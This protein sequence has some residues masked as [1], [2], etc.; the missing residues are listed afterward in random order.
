MA[1]GTGGFVEELKDLLYRH[2]GLFPPELPHVWTL[3]PIDGD[4]LKTI[5]DLESVCL[6]LGPNRNLT[7]LTGSILALHP[8][9]QVLSHGGN[10]VLP[11]E[12]INF[13]KEYS[14][15]KFQ[16]FCQFA[17]VMSQNGDKGSFGGSVVMTHA[18]RNHER[19][20]RVFRKRYGR[21]LIKEEVRSLVWKE[22]H[23]VDDFV[24][25]N[26]IDLAELL[27][28][29]EKLRFMM[30]VRNPI[31]VAYSF[32]VQH[33]IREKYF[34]HLD[35]QDHRLILD[36]V[37]ERMAKVLRLREEETERVF[38]F[39]E[40]EIGVDLF[41]RMARFL[42]I[43][44]VE[45]WVRDAAACF[46]VIPSKYTPPADL[47]AHYEKRVY[48]LFGDLPQVRDEFMQYINAPLKG[49]AVE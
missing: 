24:A 33:G 10:R 47:L 17:L 40:S 34:A 20:R 18:F 27:G 44:S 19:M 41:K 48:E 8:N 37:L 14:P 4:M 5:A 29:N 21:K 9:C 23:R 36:S 6:F 22:A 26:R 32:S 11:V 12:E 42:G 38:V 25:E 15:Q 16:T 3:A 31:D 1:K 49:Q 28:K 30:P 35:Q 39:Y 13:L 45:Q 7:T 43:R 46:E 2:A